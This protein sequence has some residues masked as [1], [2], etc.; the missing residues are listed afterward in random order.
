MGSGGGNQTSTSTSYQ[1][2]QI[3]YWTSRALG[4]AGPYYLGNL[5]MPA[6]LNA[7]TAPFT[8]Y[9]NYALSDISNTTGPASMLG[10]AGFGALGNLLA[11]NPEL[12]ALAQAN[13]QLTALAQ[14]NSTLMSMLRSS[15][16]L[17]NIAQTG[18]L[19]TENQT[20]GNLGLGGMTGML[21]NTISGKY[22]DPSTNPYLTDTFNQ[23]AKGV[24]D[25][26][27]T[28]IA[29]SLM[30]QG[31]IA[32]GGGPGALA[33]NSAFNQTQWQN[34]YGLGQTLD[35]LATNIYGGNYQQERQ[36]Q[37]AAAAQAQGLAGQANQLAETAAG[38]KLAGTQGLL[39]AVNSQ[40]G[41]EL[42]A[43]Q[44]QYGNQL[45]ATQAQ[46]QAQAQALGL[47]P[48]TQSSLYSPANQLLQAG[49]L[50]QQQQQNVLNTDWQN[51]MRAAMWPDMML[52][53]FGN[54]LGQLGQGTG[55]TV[56]TQPNTG[57]LK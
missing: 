4:A 38:N 37:L 36:N 29:P 54:L 53:N 50:Q 19:P 21:A 5:Q 15:S 14:P 39:S 20:L 28:A 45:G 23:A 8:P 26:Y 1:S 57:A 22:L 32:S 40:Q 52:S 34:Q 27:R 17:S 42:A 12:A 47:L 16:P 10:G 49:T 55:S 18:G 41:N 9:Q 44:A 6:N 56:L 24:T 30:A 7:Q 13:P 31:E 51:A 35:N 43:L 3:G 2:P 48:Q 25:Q 46:Q 11:T 33:N